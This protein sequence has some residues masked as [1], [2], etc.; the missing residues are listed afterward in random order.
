[1]PTNNLGSFVP[2]SYFI[3]TNL[4]NANNGA[5]WPPCVYGVPSK[6][7]GGSKS[8]VALKVANGTMPYSGSFISETEEINRFLLYD[9]LLGDTCLLN[10]NPAL[11]NFFAITQ[12]SGIGQLNQIE[13]ALATG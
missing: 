10:S 1:D 8:G 9:D 6:G 3:A 2:N 12:N 7:P 4:I 11:Q 5:T 13:E